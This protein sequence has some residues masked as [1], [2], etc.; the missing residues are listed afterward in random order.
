MAQTQIPALTFPYPEGTID[1]PRPVGQGCTAC[2]HKRYCGAFYW[3]IRFVEREMPP[4][5][6][7]AC[8]K[9]SNNVADRLKP[10][11]EGDKYQVEKWSIEG[12]AREPNQ[13]G[14]D[15]FTM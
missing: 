11:G 5:Y 7:V 3:H 2:V 12:V 4:E 15:D 9:W 10:K 14:A 1:K 6:G 8:P 13:N